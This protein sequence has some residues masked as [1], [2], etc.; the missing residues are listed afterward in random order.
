MS[1]EANQAA[2]TLSIAAIAFVCAWVRG[3]EMAQ[4]SRELGWKEG[5]KARSEYEGERHSKDTEG[6]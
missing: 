3:R 4:E 2:T 5:W 1:P 6:K